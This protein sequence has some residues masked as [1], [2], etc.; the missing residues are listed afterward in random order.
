MASND[1]K[2]KILLVI[3]EYN[4]GDRLEPFLKTLVNN[5]TS[6]YDIL[7]V[8]DGSNEVNVKKI[9]TIV[10]NI[11]PMP[12]GPSILTT[13]FYTPNR[14]KGAAIREGFSYR[15]K[16]HNIIGFVDADGAISYKEILKLGTLLETTPKLGAVLGSRS[17]SSETVVERAQFRELTSKLFSCLINM[18][19][20]LDIKDTQC[21]IKFIRASAYDLIEPKLKVDGFAIDIELCAYLKRNNVSVMEVPISWK[22]IN[23]SKVNIMTDAFKLIKE[24]I[25][26]RN[27]MNKSLRT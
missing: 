27:R 7:M 8:D 16:E 11:S 1:P 4:D 17:Y 19:I 20:N 2:N 24:T 9:K 14:G 21:G 18:I 23:G 10:K 12:K 25:D 5:L 26:I 15:R 6:Q 13:I 3:P 22:E